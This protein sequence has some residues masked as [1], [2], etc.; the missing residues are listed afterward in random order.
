MTCTVLWAARTLSYAS[1]A[2]KS[3]MDFGAFLASAFALTWN[4]K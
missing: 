2:K 1:F 3:T 4:S